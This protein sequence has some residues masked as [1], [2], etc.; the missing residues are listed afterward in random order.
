MYHFKQYSNSEKRGAYCD[1]VFCP[2]LAQGIKQPNNNPHNRKIL[3]NVRLL[4]VL[5]K[6]IMELNINI[7]VIHKI[8]CYCFIYDI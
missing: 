1:I 8:Y 4:P 5:S 3:N 2:T 7:N 6:C